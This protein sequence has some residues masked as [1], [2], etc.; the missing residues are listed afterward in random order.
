MVVFPEP[1]S[2]TSPRPHGP[3]GSRRLTPST[4][5]TGPNRTASALMSS[6]GVPSCA[7]AAARTVPP[8]SCSM[9][10]AL[11]VPSPP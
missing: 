3:G 6:S 11:T 1:L 10:A 4:A 7:P 5:R 8:W 2:P 9:A